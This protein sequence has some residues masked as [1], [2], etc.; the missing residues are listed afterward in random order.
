MLFNCICSIVRLHTYAQ[1][2]KPLRIIKL[3]I[4]IYIYVYVCIYIYIYI[5]A[6]NAI[7]GICTHITKDVVVFPGHK[8]RSVGHV[9]MYVC[10]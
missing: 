7:V 5:Y 9:C 4:Y 10:M 1:R 2:T 3:H 6:N 8:I